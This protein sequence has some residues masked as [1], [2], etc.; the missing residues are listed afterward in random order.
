METQSHTEPCVCTQLGQQII[1][2][3]NLANIIL[4]GAVK[5]KNL[6]AVLVAQVR[7]KLS[8]LGLEFLHQRRVDN[9]IHPSHSSADGATQTQE[10]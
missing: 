2:A 10:L 5:G 7:H 1:G 4:R 3:D 8:A 6:L 9:V